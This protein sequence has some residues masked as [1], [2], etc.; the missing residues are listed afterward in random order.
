MIRLAVV[1][2]LFIPPVSAQVVNGTVAGTVTDQ[3]G[4][5]I[6]GAKV[7]LQNEATGFTR[8]VTTNESGQYYQLLWN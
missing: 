5:V 1:L 2:L 6:A 7:V 3:A 4:A 8:E